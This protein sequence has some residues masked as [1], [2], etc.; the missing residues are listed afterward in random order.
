VRVYVDIDC[1]PH[2]RDFDQVRIPMQLVRVAEDSMGNEGWDVKV[3]VRTMFVFVV[4]LVAVVYERRLL[5]KTS[6]RVQ[7]TKMEVRWM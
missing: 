1:G 5:K 7:K 2:G 3:L 4:N 6:K